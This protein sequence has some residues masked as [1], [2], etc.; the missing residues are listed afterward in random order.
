MEFISQIIINS[1]I[2]G[3]LYTIVALGFNLIYATAK[4]FNL[5]HGVMATVGGYGVYYF[6]GLLGLPTIL[7][8][9]LG[10]LVAGLVGL[11][12]ELFIF[13]PLRS[14]GATDMVLL[15]AS[16]GIFTALESV[17]A[18]FFSD[19]FETLPIVF[20]SLKNITIFGGTLTP[21]QLLI[22]VSAIVS[23]ASLW[24]V[25]RYTKFGKASR[26]VADDET[27][28]EIVGINTG[29]IMRWIFFIASLLAGLSGILLGFDT[30][31]QPIMGLP[32]MLKGIIAS[33]IGGVGRL[34][35]GVLGAFLLGFV[36]NFGIISIS[37]EWKD[38]IA[39][40]L[41]IFFL[42]LRPQGIIS[43]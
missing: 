35:G 36:E 31:I 3:A 38:V 33:I 30:G 4:F 43:K 42:L 28:A 22:V 23:T 39:F 19:Q 32:L 18:L 7:G 10:L 25:M 2:A 12:S 21:V 1:I 9:I 13:A 17:V 11:L 24:Y 20:S 16:L 37:G 14:R 15:V 29:A 40:S 41:L 27:V 6:S 34:W 26:A 8:V 5:A